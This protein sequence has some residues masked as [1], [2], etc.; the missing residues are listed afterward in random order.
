MMTPLLQIEVFALVAAEEV[1]F[2]VQLHRVPSKNV[3][4]VDFNLQDVS[5]GH[6]HTQHGSKSL[7]YH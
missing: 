6:C 7:I 3:I 4:R 5:E 2:N 1:Y